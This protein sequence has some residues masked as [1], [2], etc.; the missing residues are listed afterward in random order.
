MARPVLGLRN[1]PM[2]GMNTQLLGSTGEPLTRP[3]SHAPVVSEAHAIAYVTH[4]T[5]PEC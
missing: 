4:Y 5:T 3:P 2:P 1:D